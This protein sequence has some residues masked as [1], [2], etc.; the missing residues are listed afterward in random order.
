MSRIFLTRR[1]FIASNGIPGI[2]RVRCIDCVRDGDLNEQM[3]PTPCCPRCFARLVIRWSRLTSYLACSNYPNCKSP[4]D[5]PKR[6]QRAFQVCR[7][8]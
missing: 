1:N 7:A 5:R 4:V 3:K 8:A 2:S 6:P